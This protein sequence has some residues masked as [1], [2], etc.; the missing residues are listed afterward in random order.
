L[1]FGGMTY[2][3]V[4]NAISPYDGNNTVCHKHLR[5]SGRT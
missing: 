4:F 5:P 2:L 3:A 1:A